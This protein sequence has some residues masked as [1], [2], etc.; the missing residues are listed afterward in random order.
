MRIPLS[1]TVR[2]LAFQY[3]VAT[4]TPLR[5]REIV[6]GAV[7]WLLPG[8]WLVMEIDSSQGSAVIDL[9]TS[10]GL[11]LVAVRRD[12][13]DRDRIAVGRRVP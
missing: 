11:D 8:G 2:A 4:E 13:A 10:A 7:D 6:H 12:F 1:K 3:F 9:M 5:V